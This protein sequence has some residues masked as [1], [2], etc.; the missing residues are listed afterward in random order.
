MLLGHGAID[1]EVGSDYEY[2][3]LFEL[4]DY[5]NGILKENNRQPLPDNTFVFWGHHG[6]QFLYFYTDTK[7]DDPLVY[8]YNE[9]YEIQDF[10]KISSLIQVLCEPEIRGKALKTV[11]CKYL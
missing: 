6:Y 1:Y 4:K 2:S 5:A 7:E 8:Y 3:W 11:K 9:C 10:L